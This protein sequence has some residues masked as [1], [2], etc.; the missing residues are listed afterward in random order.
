MDE[1]DRRGPGRPRELPA[2]PPLER[3][4]VRLLRGYRPADSE[5][6]EAPGS[7]HELPIEEARRIV[8]M[9]IA[10]RADEF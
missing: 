10:E 7:V 9:G 5:S 2:S 3:R 1:S 8:K 6:K 4:P